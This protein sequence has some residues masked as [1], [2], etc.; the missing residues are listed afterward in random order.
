[1]TVYATKAEFKS[2]PDISGTKDDAL[3]DLMLEAASAAIDGFCNRSQDGFVASAVA[4]A[5]EYVGEGLSHLWIDE[6]IQITLVEYRL[7]GSGDYQTLSTGYRGFRGSPQRP[8]FSR[9]PYMG[10]LLTSSAPIRVWPSGNSIPDS[11][12]QLTSASLQVVSEAA[13]QID[14]TVRVTGRWGYA[15]TVP[16]SVKSATIAQAARWMKR[17]QSF[18]ADATARGEFGA[19][20]YR[21]DVDPDIKMMLTNARLVRPVYGK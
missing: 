21:R 15:E 1:M 3:I 4:S 2:Q 10:I 5:R 7:T 13:R 11:W 17:G 6:S 14:A 20:M 19:L 18:W 9:T 16:P 8:N 12:G